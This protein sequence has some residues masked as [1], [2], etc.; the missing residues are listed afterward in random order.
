MN[1][2]ILTGCRLY[3]KCLKGLHATFRWKRQRKKFS[4]DTDKLGAPCSLSQKRNTFASKEKTEHK[5]THTPTLFL[6]SRNKAQ[7]YESYRHHHLLGLPTLPDSAR[8]YQMTFAFAT[9]FPML[10]QFPTVAVGHN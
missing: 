2:F 6:A 7:A 5:H 8:A 1:L 10:I 3:F 9:V 4:V